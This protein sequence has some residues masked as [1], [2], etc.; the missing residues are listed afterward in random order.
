MTERKPG[1]VSWQTWIDRQV[2]QAQNRGEFD[3]LAGKGRPLA[4]VDRS[5]PDQVALGRRG[6]LQRRSPQARAAGLDRGVGDVLG[7]ES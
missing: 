4:D 1:G 5:G 3:N 7:P 2:E 6:T